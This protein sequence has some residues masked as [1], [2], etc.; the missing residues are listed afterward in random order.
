MG[1]IQEKIKSYVMYLSMKERKER[2]YLKYME[3]FNRLKDL[4]ESRLSSEYINTK[5]KYEYKKNKLSI[6]VIAI[7]LAVLTDVWKY[8]YKFI[9]QILLFA[10][11]QQI[12]AIDIAIT[13][14]MIAVIVSACVTSMIIFLL[15]DYIKETYSVHRHLLIIEEIRLKSK[16]I[17]EDKIWTSEV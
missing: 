4:S 10:S 3:E 12:D 11:N 17:N 15:I 9:E 5:S 14:F 16:K 7:V 6:F 2:E 8:F 13:G 1:E